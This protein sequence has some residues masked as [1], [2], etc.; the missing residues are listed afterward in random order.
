MPVQKC[1]AAAMK[2]LYRMLVRI[3]LV[4]LHTFYIVRIVY[5]A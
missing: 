4:T 1:S 3:F 5:V 2:G